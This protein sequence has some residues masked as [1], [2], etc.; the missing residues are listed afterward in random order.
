MLLRFSSQSALCCYYCSCA[1]FGVL[2][3]INN[4]IDP[5]NPFSKTL[6]WRLKLINLL[7]TLRGSLLESFFPA[8]WD[9]EQVD[10]CVA[11]DPAAILERQNHWHSDFSIQMA[12][13]VADF[14]T[15]MGHELAMEIRRCQEEGRKLALILPV[16][17]MG[18]YRW[19]IYFLQAWE[20][21]CDHVTALNMDEWSDAEGN[22]LPGSDPRAFQRAME[23]AFYDPLGEA[24]V[25]S[26]QRFFATKE[27]LPEYH[28]RISA[29]RRRVP[30]W[31]LFL[32]SDV[33]F[34]S[35]SGSPTS[36]PNLTATKS[37]VNRPTVWEPNCTPL[38]LNKTQLRVSKAEPPLCPPSPTQLVPSF[39]PRPIT[40][41][42]VRTEKWD[43]AC[44]GRVCLFG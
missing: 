1:R 12:D 8:A 30:S 33:P 29:L 43:A 24:T 19:A 15:M 44:S 21:S 17:P 36:V 41:S 42:G 38:P 37:G 20:V 31:W 39:S 7:T 11:D 10:A 28:Q 27:M 9:L 25:P 16:G 18:M 13:T 5:S 4:R 3:S 26:T 35:L 22:T 32:G 2:S 6:F 34:T 14:D 23:N 40:S